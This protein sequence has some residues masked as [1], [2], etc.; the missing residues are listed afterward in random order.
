M[1]CQHRVIRL[2]LHGDLKGKHTAGLRIRKSLFIMFLLA[3]QIRIRAD[4]FFFCT[5]LKF[6]MDFE[7]GC[8]AG[9]GA[10][11]GAARSRPF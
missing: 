9:A 7:Q 4:E 3:L 1:L 5:W 10:G 11:A 8:G 6:L 2:Q